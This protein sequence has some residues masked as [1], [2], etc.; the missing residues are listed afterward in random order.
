MGCTNPEIGK[1]IGRYEFGLLNDEEKKKFEL[2][3]MECDDCFEELYSLSPAVK[4]LRDNPEFYLAELGAKE[5]LFAKLKKLWNDGLEA[6]SSVL[7]IRPRLIKVAVP[8]IATTAVAVLV[9]T[10]FLSQP[11]EYSRLALI[12]KDFYKPLALRTGVDYEDYE[13]LYHDGMVAYVDGDYALAIKNL[14]KSVRLNPNYPKGQFYLGLSYLLKYKIDEAIHYLEKTISTT[15][16]ETLLEKSHWYLGNAYL[17]RDKGSKALKEFR[18]V[19][20]FQGRFQ[21]DAE[22]MVGKIKKLKAESLKRESP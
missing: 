22:E 10:I 5:P 3:L 16:D 7:R 12:E 20:E 21:S 19:I 1:F 13:I 9:M 6:L 18:K 17:K 4:A 2:H 8:V 15:D 11:G 14:S